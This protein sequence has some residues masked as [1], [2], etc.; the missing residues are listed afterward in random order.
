MNLAKQRT[1]IALVALAIAAL[2]YAYVDRK[3]VSDAERK[4][5]ETDVFPAYRRQDVARVELVQGDV[6]LAFERRA[7]G[8]A[9]DTTWWMTSPRDERADAATVD[10]LLGDIEFAGIVRKVDP[11]AAAG[12]DTPRVKG[13]IAMGALVYRFALGDPAPTPVGAS[14]FRVDG[15]GTFVVTRDFTTSLLKGP[16]AY[17]ERTVVPYLSLELSRLAVRGQGAAFA[18]ERMDDVSFRLPELGLRASR[19]TLDRVWG[20]LAE[21]RA[22]SF[23]KDEEADRAIG[24]DPITIDM[25]PRD[26][27]KKDG[28]LLVGGP[29]PGHPDDVVAVRRAPT[30]L[31]ACVPKGMIPGL[32]ITAAELVDTRLFAARGDESAELLLE[33]VPAGTKVELARKGSGWHERSPVDHDLGSDEV[34]AAND[35]VSALTKGEGESVAPGDPKARFAAR[36]SIRVQRADN[37]GDEIVELG[38]VA[39][40]GGAFVR[41]A[42]DG[43]TLRV[44]EALAH[45]LVPSAIAL[46]GR[47]VFV[48]SLEGKIIR[49]LELRCDG[50]SQRLTRDDGGWS[51]VEPSGHPVDSAGAADL[52]N[53]VARSRADSWVADTDD[54][55]FGFDASACSITMSYEQEGGAKAV[56]VV[57]GR[58]AEG[59]G[60]YAHLLGQ[61]AVFLAPK[62]LHDEAGRLLV[63][64][65]GF[66]V[67]S[68]EVF[69][70]TMSRAGARLVLARRGGKLLLGDGGGVDVGEKVGL[71]LEALRADEVVH[72]G[73]PR[74]TEGF[75]H[76]S[77]DV[78][79]RT[80]SEAGAKDVHFVVGDSALVLKERMFYARLEGVDATFAIARDRLAPLLDAF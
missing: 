63:E 29:C 15:E 51:L 44:S 45:R 12:L 38:P 19:E 4:D 79:V 18:I 25:K 22:E 17:R 67:D 75:S 66:H 40:E 52:V 42:G 69:T 78:R 77:L 53:I 72:L 13:S 32:V 48:P 30:R 58:T 23:L 65:S 6:R 16:D 7:E 39:P 31:S 20:A 41:R 70:V 9:G 47:Q 61:P 60:Y 57:F 1:N 10:K 50:T 3:S 71:A 76:P 46:R 43:A 26:A 64:R 62:S 56:G 54:G 80:T 36:A 8:D 24:P 73:P 2:V 27:S 33:S 5:R 59:G 28:E 35:L 49:T 37:K 11:T 21:G 68:A 34:D 74:P 55:S 14:Y